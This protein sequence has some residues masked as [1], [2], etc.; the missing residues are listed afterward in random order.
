M[1]RAVHVKQ[2]EKLLSLAGYLGGASRETAIVP[3][4]HPFMAP[5][6]PDNEIDVAELRRAME[7]KEARHLDTFRIVLERCYRLIRRFASVRKYA[8]AFEVPEFI[9]GHPLYDIMKCIEYVVR[10]L[11][12]N[13]YAVQYVMPRTILVSWQI[14]QS[15]QQDAV[16]RS[17]LQLQQKSIDSALRCQE[18]ERE[19][20]RAQ[21]AADEAAVP[22]PDVLHAQLRRGAD[23]AS[24]HPVQS[25]V[26]TV[27][28]G[29]GGGFP[30]HPMS[31]RLSDVVAGGAQGQAAA[32]TSA[33]SVS[34]KSI[35]EFKPSGKFVL[36]V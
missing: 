25:A 17:I 36:H 19:S 21:E 32:P 6:P 34:F 4:P 13:G 22:S 15:K 5:M 30:P 24:S 9:P 20:T 8:C 14:V 23:A 33:K 35:A 1:S 2:G 26:D 11:A 3:A 28:L 16:I 31:T 29:T 27:L 18:K 12:S 10:N 7:Q